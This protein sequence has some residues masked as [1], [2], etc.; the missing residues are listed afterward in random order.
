MRLI[1]LAVILAR[2]TFIVWMTL[3]TTIILLV[4]SGVSQVSEAQNLDPASV[5]KRYIE[6]QNAGD[7]DTALALWAEDS[8]ITNTRGRSFVGH[9]SLKQFIRG[10]ISRRIKQEPE[11]IQVGGDRV[12]WINRE[13][14]ESYIRLNV[15]PVQQNS[16][17]IVRGGKIISWVNY[18]PSIEIVRIER[19]CLTAA[20]ASEPSWWRITKEVS[21]RTCDRRRAAPRDAP[22][23]SRPSRRGHRG[24]SRTNQRLGRPES[25]GP[26]PGILV[27]P[28]L[29]QLLYAST[30][31][32]VVV[33]T[34]V[35]MQGTSPLPRLA[36]ASE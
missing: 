36:H 33:L 2:R 27:A 34:A 28:M 4:V 26:A 14:N 35:K 8:V 21:R 16:E 7:L 25:K 19:A 22:R 24:W 30:K 5:L 15:A 31:R 17:I 10:N 18:F 13:S 32:C 20:V 6:A 3:T 11:S 12:T 29:A 1:G 9:E 23:A